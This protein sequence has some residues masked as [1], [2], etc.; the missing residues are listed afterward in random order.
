[1]NIHPRR[2]QTFN[3]RKSTVANVLLIGI[4]VDLSFSPLMNEIVRK[5]QNSGASSET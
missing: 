1:M 5:L 4:R 3:Q 2:E